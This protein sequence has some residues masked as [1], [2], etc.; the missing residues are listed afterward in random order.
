MAQSDVRET[1]RSL[2]HSKAL[3]VGL[4][5]GPKKG[6]AQE[7]SPVVAVAHM[8]DTGVFLVSEVPL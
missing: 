3:R 1:L 8:R 2:D 5:Q 6:E 4:M 7:L